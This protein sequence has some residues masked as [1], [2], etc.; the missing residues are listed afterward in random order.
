M[1]K[2]FWAAIAAIIVIF[3]G[4][5]AL[6]NRHSNTATNSNAKPT[7]HLFGEGT[8]GVKLVEYGDYQC[9]FCGQYYPI[10][11]QVK[12]KYKTQVTFQ[13]RNLPLLQVH[14]N[15]FAAARAAEAASLQGKFWEMYSLLYQNQQSWSSTTAA[16]SIFEQY[17]SQ[18]KLNLDQYKK[19]FASSQVNDTINADIAEFNKTKETMSTP[20]FFLD[21]KKV[22]PTSVDEFSKLIDAEIALKQKAS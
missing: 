10:V 6:S 16:T 15:A 19:D 12:E 8:T 9:P 21:G 13:F 3:G 7:N 5:V 4:I 2:T 14:Q 11:E 17:A 1:S 18:L 20:T 22:Q